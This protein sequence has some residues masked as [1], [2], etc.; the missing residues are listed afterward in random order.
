MADVE[1]IFGAEIGYYCP[2]KAIRRQR[3]F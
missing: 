1:R 3:I 2:R